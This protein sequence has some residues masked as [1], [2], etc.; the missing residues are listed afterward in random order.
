[1]ISCF[2]FVIV[3]DF[4]KKGELVYKLPDNTLVAVLPQLARAVLLRA[5]ERQVN[6]TTGER[7][8]SMCPPHPPSSDTIEDTF[9]MTLEEDADGGN[10]PID[11]ARVSPCL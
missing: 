6:Q 7:V 5:H 8:P 4:L 10:R 11:T 3:R 1:M 2:P 9:G